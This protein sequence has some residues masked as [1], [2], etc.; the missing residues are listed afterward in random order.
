MNQIWQMHLKFIKQVISVGAHCVSASAGLG[1]DGS[2][3]N[4]YLFCWT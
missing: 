2:T 4:N 1:F 3:D